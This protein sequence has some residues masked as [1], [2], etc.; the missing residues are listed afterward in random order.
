ML[1]TDM[2][3]ARGFEV[4]HDSKEWRI[5]AHTYEK[6]VNGIEAFLTWGIHETSEEAFLLLSGKG[7]LVTSREGKDPEDYQIHE[8]SIDK[9]CVV[10]QAERHA[11]ILTP[12]SQALIVE[13][14]DMS[15]SRTEPVTEAVKSAVD[16]KIKSS[17]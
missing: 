4:L 7:W 11:I 6:E 13:N 2:R 8:L 3:A 16:E 12:G 1:E 9:L 10:E 5:A 14:E 17:R 15:V